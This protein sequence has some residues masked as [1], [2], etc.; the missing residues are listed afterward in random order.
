MEGRCRHVASLLKAPFLLF[1]G[2]F[3]PAAQDSPAFE[4]RS[5][6]KC[7][8][9]RYRLRKGWPGYRN[10]MDLQGC[11]LRAPLRRRNAAIVVRI[12]KK[13]VDDSVLVYYM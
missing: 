13:V 3:R 2:G 11:S 12:R 8:D 6:P 7:P 4:R 5:V 10:S 9:I 1:P